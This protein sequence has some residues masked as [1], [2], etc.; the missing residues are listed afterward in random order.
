MKPNAL[1]VL[2][3]AGLGFVTAACVLAWAPRP[4]SAQFSPIQPGVPA[5][6]TGTQ[7]SAPAPPQPIEIQPLSPKEFVVATREP[8]IVTR[9]GRE[10]SAQNM[11]VTV[12]VHY[13]VKEDRLVPIEHVRVPTGYRLVDLAP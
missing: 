10:G 6:S 4:A 2:A 13:T 11:L 8:R 5:L 9:L 1:S 7:T 12:V 3:A